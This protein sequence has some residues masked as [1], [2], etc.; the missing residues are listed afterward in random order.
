MGKR[1]AKAGVLTGEVSAANLRAFDA[2]EADRLLKRINGLR[3][4]FAAKYRFFG[5]PE[6]RAILICDAERELKVV[7]PALIR[8]L[9]FVYGFGYGVGETTRAIG[10]GT[11]KGSILRRRAHLALLQ[12]EGG[13]GK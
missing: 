9:L 3:A 1:G 12:I 4:Y 2:S 8:F 11:R 10:W 5:N 13:E 6:T 7:D